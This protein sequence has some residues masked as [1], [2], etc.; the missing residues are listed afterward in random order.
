MI[1]DESQVLDEKIEYSGGFWKIEMVSS[2]E[3]P[4]KQHYLG[5]SRSGV[6]RNKSGEKNAVRRER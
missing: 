5:Y 4:P 1:F 6:I 2:A 3:N